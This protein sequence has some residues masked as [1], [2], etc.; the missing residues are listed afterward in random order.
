MR[1]GVRDALVTHDMLHATT[2]Y[3]GIGDAAADWQ[4]G[5]PNRGPR[6]GN[7]DRVLE[8]Q[9]TIYFSSLLIEV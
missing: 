4:K 8:S 2:A 7:A 5:G 3:S 9:P 1:C 6:D